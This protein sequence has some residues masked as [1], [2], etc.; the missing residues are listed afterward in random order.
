VFGSVALTTLQQLVPVQAH[1][2]VMGV[3]GTIQSAADT[4]GQPIAGVTIAAL[5]V[6]AGGLGL[7]GVSVLAGLSCLAATALLPALGHQAA[8]NG[9]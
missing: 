6:R 5:G 7:A 1:G 9:E 8:P 2:R 4:I 3:A